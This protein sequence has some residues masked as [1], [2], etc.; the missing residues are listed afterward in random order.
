MKKWPTV[1]LE[2]ICAFIKDGTHQTPTYCDN[3]VIFLSSKNVTSGK[4]DWNN[5]KFI[6]HN[7]HEAIKGQHT[8]R[9]NDILLAKNGTTGIA[10][11]VDRDCTFSFYVSLAHIRPLPTVHPQYLL[12]VINSDLCKKQFNAHLKGIGVP[13]LHLSDIR[14]TI[15]PLPPLAEQ[16]RIAAILDKADKLRRKDEELLRKYNEL[17]QAIFIDMFGD[18]VKNEKGW[19]IGTIRDIATEVK[20]GTSKPS[21]DEGKFKYIRMNNITFSGDWDFSDLKHITITD[22]EKHKYT[23][24]NGD[25]VFNRTNS[26]EL[27]GKT[28]V[29]DQT[30]EMVI[31]GY[32]IR[33]RFNDQGNPYYVSGF[34]NSKPGKAILRNMCKD[35][36]GMANIN[37]QELQDIQIAIPPI[38][39]QNE[40]QK[41]YMQI[42]KQKE[43]SALA[44]QKSEDLF[45]SLLQKAFSGQL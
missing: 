42:K 7:L 41:S 6:P 38:A 28:A 44:S 39:I 18:P 5:T 8:P 26:K 15:I 33:V 25:L 37:A 35:I 16:K 29:Y 2:D 11:I 20:Y 3:G 36:I 30:E 27:V 45:Q 21:S 1:K 4:I 17:A 34:L 31:A 32:L 14:K 22:S 24:K 13:N 9:I 23:I 40:Y 12:F 10:A 43:T 19:K